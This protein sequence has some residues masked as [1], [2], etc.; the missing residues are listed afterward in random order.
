MAEALSFGM[1]PNSGFV[2]VRLVYFL[3]LQ[4]TAGLPV[5]QRPAKL[6]FFCFF[7]LYAQSFLLY[8]YL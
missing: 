7:V 1:L 2:A 6:I 4:F 3:C 8:D 5:W